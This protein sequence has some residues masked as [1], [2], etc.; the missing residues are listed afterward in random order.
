[1]LVVHQAGKR[2]QQIG[3]GLSVAAAVSVSLPSQTSLQLPTSAIKDQIADHSRAWVVYQPNSGLES[4]VKALTWW[5]SLFR[6]HQ[7]GKFLAVGEAQSRNRKLK[8]FLASL[9]LDEQ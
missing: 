9:H 8:D 2:E 3:T 4:S 7:L 6:V 1:M 5:A